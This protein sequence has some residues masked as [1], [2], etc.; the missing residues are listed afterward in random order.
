MNSNKGLT[1]I[2][3][4]IAMAISGMLLTGIIGVYARA[5]R[6]YT[7]QEA[8]VNA[9][10]GLR[11]SLSIMALNLSM[12]GYNPVGGVNPD[13][14]APDFGIEVATP[15]RIRFTADYNMNGQIDNDQFERVTY[16]ID[17]AAR[18]LTE[19]LYEGT[20][21]QEGPNT[22]M[23]NMN[24]A[25][26]VFAYFDEDGNAL[27]AVPADLSAIRNVLVLLVVDEPA[28]QQGTIQRR[29][30]RRVICPNLYF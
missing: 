20:A 24:V 2:E 28:G 25:D 3:L 14:T 10:E 6:T 19:T 8:L 13:P 5:T 21:D 16:E 11:G 15:N 7:G 9:Q 26:S 23:G 18:N 27:A 4:M 17:P 30:F 12:A 22:L 29:L 1:L